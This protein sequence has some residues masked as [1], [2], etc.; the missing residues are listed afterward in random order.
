MTDTVKLSE[1]RPIYTTALTSPFELDNNFRSALV[2]SDPMVK[3]GTYIVLCDHA[4]EFDNTTRSIEWKYEGVV[5]SITFS[6][7]Q[8]SP[9]D[10]VPRNY[11]FK[12]TLDVD[13]PVTISLEI[14]KKG[15]LDTAKVVA[16]SISVMRV[17]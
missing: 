16:G 13:S 5:N 12:F 2:L 7:K 3:A 11:I 8:K 17:L 9:S 14:R 6:A 10:I 15:N 1:Y 4:V